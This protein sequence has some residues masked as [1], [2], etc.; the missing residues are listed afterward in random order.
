MPPFRIP[1]PRGVNAL[2]VSPPVLAATERHCELRRFHRRCDLP[3]PAGVSTPR[4]RP[5]RRCTAA[6]A[7]HGSFV[8]RAKVETWRYPP[9][10]QRLPERQ[11]RSCD[12]AS[13]LQRLLKSPV[14]FRQAPR[15]HQHVGPRRHL[16]DAAPRALDRPA[17]SAQPA[18]SR[19]EWYLRQ[20]LLLLL[21]PRRM[22]PAAA[23]QHAEQLDAAFSAAATPP[24]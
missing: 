23:H 20:K 3:S 5:Y 12:D 9:P 16:V 7:N 11:T 6:Q 4:A 24:C 19:R 18:L 8:H 1:R 15:R 10:S 14:A 2:L 13:P 17:P 21:L 22:H